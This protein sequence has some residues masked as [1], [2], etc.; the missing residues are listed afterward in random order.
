MV[1][2]IYGFGVVVLVL[3]TGCSGAPDLNLVL[4]EGTVTLDGKPLANKGLM[5]TPESGNGISAGGNTDGS[6]KYKLLATV[7][8]ATSDQVG[9]PPGRYKVTVYEPLIPIEGETGDANFEPM[10]IP[11]E[12]RSEVPKKYQTV[13]TT[14][15]VK[16]VPAGG[17]TINVEL[18]LGSTSAPAPA[19][20]STTE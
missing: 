10:I 13:E 18:T 11:G 9:V 20:E 7:Q 4:V 15:L 6:G 1:R 2:R 17:G 16:E 12:S 3:F 19:P 8:G 5:F 14:D